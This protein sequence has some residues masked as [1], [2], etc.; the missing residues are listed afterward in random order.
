MGSFFRAYLLP[1]IV[2]QSVLIGGAYATG[3]E[4]VQYGARFGAD[5]WWSILAIGLG[6]SIMA[7]LTFEFARRNR[8]YDYQAFMRA[9][10]GTA[11][12]LFDL[13]Y[14][15]MVLITV[16]VVIAASVSVAQQVLGLHTAIAM[17]TVLAIV[18]ALE[19]AGRRYIER[20]KTAGSILLYGAFAL[21][22]AIVIGESW[23]DVSRVLT[24]GDSTFDAE[25]SVGT[26][27]AIGGLYV[28]YNLGAMPAT[29]FVLDGQNRLRHSIGA[30][31]VTGLLS[32]V[33]FVLTYLAL[34]GHYPDDSVLGAEV[35][36]LQMLPASVVAIYAV[37]VLWTLVETSTGMIHAVLHRIGARRT[38]SATQV[39][40][41]TAGILI[42]AA[43][44]SRL[45]LIALVA[46]GYGLLAY[47][48]LLLFALPLVVR[49]LLRRF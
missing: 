9:L 4:I 2:F 19:V 28:A 12:P 16:A 5:G 32:T 21:F 49:C 6:F 8:A 26:L 41:I 11:W 29:L 46:R 24:T 30:G 1:G 43:A 48:F 10:V 27:L 40:V 17:A 37:V 44:M 3:R 23:S 47:G 20:F 25:R 18:V 14:A 31:V 13:V 15:C 45:G 36:W 38:L 22:A 34:M 7:A 39:A 42:L 33:P 35:P